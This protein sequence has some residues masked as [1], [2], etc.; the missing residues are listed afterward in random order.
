MTYLHIIISD[1]L[2]QNHTTNSGVC[3]FIYLFFSSALRATGKNQHNKGQS[4]KSNVA[5]LKFRLCSTI[6][7]KQENRQ[8][9]LVRKSNFLLFVRVFFSNIILSNEI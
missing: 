4:K 9:I 3:F 8:A 1:R 6:F 2:R 7:L 5:I